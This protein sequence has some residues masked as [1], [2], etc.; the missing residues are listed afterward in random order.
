MTLAG[1]LDCKDGE[2]QSEQIVCECLSIKQCLDQVVI[3]CSGQG[4]TL[5]SCNYRQC[6]QQPQ[7]CAEVWMSEVW[8][9]TNP[10]PRAL[11]GMETSTWEKL[12]PSHPQSCEW[13]ERQQEILLDSYGRIWERQSWWGRQWP[14]HKQRSTLGRYHRLAGKT[15]PSIWKPQRGQRGGVPRAV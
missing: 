10:V 1:A 4:V 12:A 7:G 11:A 14:K 15:L 9:R 8:P 6:P 3:T 2:K 13:F 5:F